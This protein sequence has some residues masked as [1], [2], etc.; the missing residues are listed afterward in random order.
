MRALVTGAGGF[1]GSHVVRQLLAKN[2]DVIATVRSSQRRLEENA[3]LEIVPCDL[4][5]Q[6]DGPKVDVVFS[7]AATADPA[8]AIADPWR[9]YVNDTQVML[10]T[11]DYARK[12]GA[13]VVHVSSN[14]AQHPNGAYA[15]AKACQDIICDACS[16]VS[17]TTVITQSLFGERQQSNRL[18]PNAIRSLLADRP[19]PLQHRDGE[20]AT[21][22]F[23]HAGWAAEALITAAHLD[24]IVYRL[25]SQPLPLT[26]VVETIAKALDREAAYRVIASDDRPGHELHGLSVGWSPP[27][28]KPPERDGTL[29]QIARTAVW[30]RDH[31]EWLDG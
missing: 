3:R 13:K 28:G 4:Q 20:C 15:G 31:P 27:F 30:F 2:W 19:V 1:L 8:R 6:M 16:G 17:I 26:L 29:A 10:T 11:L 12:V 5:C 24:P 25:G 18:I 22:P 21:R 7:L 14:E 23:L 9:A